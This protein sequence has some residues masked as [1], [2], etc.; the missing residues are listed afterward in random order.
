MLVYHVP[1][2]SLFFY[3]RHGALGG[4]GTAG[5]FGVDLFFTLSGYLITRLLLRE[6]ETTGHISLR[7]FYVRR[8]LRIWPLYFFYLAFAFSLSR[9]APAVTFVPTFG[10][11][12]FP[13]DPAC[14][15]FLGCF[16][17]NFAPCVMQATLVAHLWGISLEEQF[18]LA[19]SLTMRNIPRRRILVAPL[20]MLVIAT[21][22]RLP[23][24][25]LGF[26]VPIWNNS[27]A[28]LDPIAAGIFVA[29]L[30]E[31]HPPPAA[32]ALLVLMGIAG[33]W[34]AAYWCG[35]QLQRNAVGVLIGYP[36]VALGS[37]AFLSAT[38]GTGRKSAGTRLKQTL[39][40]LGKISYGLY[41]YN[42]V[43]IFGGQLL[44]R[45]MVSPWLLPQGCPPWIERSV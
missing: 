34:V 2:G 13:A 22:A 37:G 28:R 4:F 40:Y 18:Y 43:A 26:G 14:L 3:L 5:S 29:V 36:M 31:M 16:L 33:W 7:A 11:V 41:V 1:P 12:G 10:R 6:R 27:F 21:I 42:L 17:F 38:L 32:R 19:W 30:P 20:V 25:F 24:S 23:S 45:H 35:L 39:I 8:I 15:L 44:M 9:L